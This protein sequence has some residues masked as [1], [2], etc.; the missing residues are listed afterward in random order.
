MCQGLS[1]FGNSKGIQDSKDTQ[2]HIGVEGWV[3]CRQV[4]N[5]CEVA[6]PA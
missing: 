1:T 3:S 5:R 4:A 6:G 2:E